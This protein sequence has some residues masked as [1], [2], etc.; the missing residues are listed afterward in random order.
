MFPNLTTKFLLYR[1][2]NSD[3]EH[4]KRILVVEVTQHI[5]ETQTA[6]IKLLADPKSKQLS[7]ESCCIGLAACQGIAQAISR[8]DMA[9]D[10]KL[11]DEL[12]DSLLRAFG[13]T[14]NFGGSAMMETA[15]QNAERRRRNNPESG[16]DAPSI[17]EPFG[18]DTE[19]GGAAGLG[20]A[21]LGAYREMA[22]AAL[23]LGRSDVLYALFLLSISHPV[24]FTSGRRDRYSA[25]TLLGEFSL[26]GS[27]TNSAEMREALRPHLSKLIPRM[28]RAC[29]DPNKQTR[30]Q[31]STLWLGVTGGGAESR[32][33]ITENLL[34]TIDILMEDAANKLWRARVG[35][36]GALAEVIVGR[37]WDDLG[38]GPAILDDDD[39]V[40][41]KTS[42]SS[43]TAAVRLLRLWRVSMRALDDVRLSVRESGETLVR[44]VRSLTI[45]LCDPSALHD[46]ANGGTKPTV[47]EQQEAIESAKA[48]AATCLR[49]LVKHGLNQPCAEA[50]GACVSCL[51][52]I[53]EVVQP[54][55]L[56]PVLSEL[57][58]ALLMAMSG[59]EPAALNYLQVRSAGRDAGG[60]DSYDRLERARLQMASSG[61]VAGALNKCLD[62]VPSVELSAQRELIPQLDYALRSGV[63]TLL[64]LICLFRCGSSTNFSFSVGFA[65]RAATA[66]AVSSLCA[67]SP[68]AFN[69]PGQGTNNPTVRLLRA[70]YYASEREHGQGARDKMAHALGNLAA[71]SPGQ[72]VRSLALR[73]CE[74]YSAATGNN[75]E[76]VARRAAASAL[77][78]LAVRASNQLE[79]GG[80]RDIWCR[81]VL[82]LAFLGQRD[83]DAKVASLWKEVWDEGGVATHAVDEPRTGSISFGVMLEEK[84]LPELVGACVDALNDVSWA[85]RVSACAALIELCDQN[86]LSPIPRSTKASIDSFPSSEMSRSKRRAQASLTALSA[87]VRLM[88][89]PRVWT[90]KTEVV[91][92]ATRIAGRWVVVCSKNDST[93]LGW[94]DT[95]KVCPWMPLS[96]SQD[97]LGKDLFVGDEWF[98]NRQSVM[99]VSDENNERLELETEASVPDVEMNET[100]D[101][102]KIDFEKA[103]DLLTSDTETEEVSSSEEVVDSVTFAGLCKALLEQ[104]F[105]RNAS[106]VSASLA[107]DVL[108]YRASSLA[109]LSE[110]LQALSDIPN[111]TDLLLDYQI[112]VYRMVAPTLIPVIGKEMYQDAGDSEEKKSEPPLIVARAVDC[113]ASAFWKGL[114]KNAE[115]EHPEEDVLSLAEI[116]RTVGGSKQPAWTVRQSSALCAASLTFNIS[117]HS[118]RNPR[119]VDSLLDSSKYALSDRKFWRVRLAGLE[120]LLALV[121]RAGDSAG[122]SSSVFSMTTATTGSS[123]NPNQ[124]DTQ[125]AL[126][127]LL[128]HK[129][130][131]LQL[132]RSSLTDS[133][134]RVTSKA[135]DVVS[136]M[137]WWP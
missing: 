120:L 110:L 46:T 41:I 99:D 113:L 51:L 124:Q 21:A 121:K 27:R 96:D 81:R 102:E 71:I 82:P 31:M 34:P 131:I 134:A 58:G 133:E 43:T 111:T 1:K 85:R 54:A 136:G 98:E 20:E 25:A 26:I 17:T 11:S 89:K 37:S 29:H 53:V 118:L 9:N 73:A 59:L 5:A 72:S 112:A 115:E 129:E 95:S 62:M 94:N 91:K 135:S 83:A 107:E 137:A 14:T 40:F 49:W 2:A 77:R 45:R 125:L 130:T 90:G 114:G 23:A 60:G 79:D 30:E 69:F 66:D 116:L 63:G 119:L 84:L 70:L 106:H 57:I 19:V 18:I 50:V 78:A 39:D 75:D 8:T 123:A 28:L 64:I 100:E 109:G 88:I 55:T 65:T 13:Q 16:T 33:A 87:C 132:A 6:F 105:P 67:A 36:C 74:R 127:A 104:A 15:S 56:Q 22:A 68:A 44:S 80:P 61:P 7:R 52:G 86:I 4:A 101:E 42:T 12:N 93:A 3:K 35:A 38:G 97:S 10:M 32:K 108:P 92:A 103:D 48:A 47:E 76:P 126:E 24:W 122:G 128:P 117:V